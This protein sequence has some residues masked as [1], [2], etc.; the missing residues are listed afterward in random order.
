MCWWDDNSAAVSSEDL[1]W[2]VVVGSCLVC[3]L[4]LKLC[5]DQRLG[6]ALIRGQTLSGGLPAEA[7]PPIILPSRHLIYLKLGC[8]VFTGPGPLQ[9]AEVQ[10]GLQRH[11]CT[12]HLLCHPDTQPAERRGGRRRSDIHLCLASGRSNLGFGLIIGF[13]TGKSLTCCSLLN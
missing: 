1:G 13:Y 3:A 4:L 9:T 8:R 6:E 12:N 2:E 7:G 11:T 10:L 5:W